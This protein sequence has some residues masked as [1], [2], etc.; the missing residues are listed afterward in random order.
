MLAVAMVIALVALVTTTLSS[1]S[2]KDTFEPPAH[3][4]PPS[5]PVTPPLDFSGFDPSNIISDEEF[6]N[7]RALTQDQ[8]TAFITQW[9]D[10]CRPSPDGTPCLSSYREDTADIP[11]D[12][13]CDG[14]AGQAGDTPASIIS[15]TALSC[16]I[17]P[18]V[19][20]VMLQKEQGLITA[21]GVKLVPSR[22][23]SAMGYACPDR[24]AC[25]PQYAGFATQVFHAARQ[26]RIYEG[27]PG[28]YDVIPGQVN[29][30]RFHPD[31]ACGGSDVM[32]ENQATANLYNYTPYQPN[33]AALA[34]H[35][36]DQCSSW[37]NANFYAYYHAWFTRS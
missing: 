32:V 37:G 9:N 29:T 24:Q 22:Y 14:F 2:K 36:G 18:E 19:L 25:D 6:F 30:I 35:P 26:F 33:D 10:G 17:N 15:K 11:A 7:D 4:A 13:Y 28:M 27:A 23:A 16:G 31:E 5:G 20:L 1:R 34:G 12:E 8:I 3:S 21:S